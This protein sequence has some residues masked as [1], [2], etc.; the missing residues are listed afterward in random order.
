MLRAQSAMPIDQKFQAD[1]L[2][3]FEEKGIQLPV[4]KQQRLK[5]ILDQLTKIEQEYS[6]N[7]RDNKQKLEFTAAELK[8]LPQS[9]IDAVKKNEKGN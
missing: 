6:R 2:K 8:G 9:Y 1:I 3:D 4:D 7:V 5:E